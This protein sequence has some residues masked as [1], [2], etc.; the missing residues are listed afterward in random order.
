[1]DT[2]LFEPVLTEAARLGASNFYSCN[3]CQQTILQLPQP[4]VRFSEFPEIYFDVAE[5]YRR[6]W[7]EES[8][9][10]IDIVDGI[11]LVLVLKNATVLE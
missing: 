6:P 1:M 10:R 4:R 9:Q 7:L 5:I 3:D 11:H 2:I 8:G